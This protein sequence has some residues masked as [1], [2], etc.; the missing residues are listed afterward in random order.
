LGLGVWNA[1]PVVKTELARERPRTHAFIM[2]SGSSGGAPSHLVAGLHSRGVLPH[3][4]R[5]GAT[6]FIT[7]R[8]A[9]TLPQAVHLKFKAERSVLIAAAEAARRPLTW[10]EQEEVFRWYSGRVDKYLVS[11]HGDCWLRQP[12]IA[13][14]VANAIRFH[15]G[16]DES[17]PSGALLPA[18][19]LALEQ[20]LSSCHVSRFGLCCGSFFK[21][22][23]QAT[24]K[25]PL[26]AD[27]NVGATERP[28][29]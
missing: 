28:R 20:R 27:K 18:G 6:Y 22:W 13:D 19:G 15:A 1:A 12:E 16:D 11:G 3:L 9:G 14:L 29:W 5:E 17:R 2:I 25:S 8:L 21:R 7:F 10:Q 26:L 23:E 4:K 24:G